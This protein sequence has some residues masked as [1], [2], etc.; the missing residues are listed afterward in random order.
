MGGLACLLFVEGLGEHDVCGV[1]AVGEED[2]QEVLVPLPAGR[3]GWWREKG[4]G[5]GGEGCG[6]V[7]FGG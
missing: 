5:G 6:E 3:G 7:G 2:L 4:E 1:T